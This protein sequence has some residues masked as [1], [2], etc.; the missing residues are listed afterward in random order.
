MDATRASLASAYEGS[1]RISRVTTRMHIGS[2]S[3]I[4]SSIMIA[5]TAMSAINTEESQE[6][7]QLASCAE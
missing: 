2:D 3:A 1:D 4:R 6:A 7:W 5:S